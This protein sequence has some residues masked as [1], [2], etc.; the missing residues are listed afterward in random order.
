MS[1]V[2]WKP[3][4]AGVAIV[5]ALLILPLALAALL[6]KVGSAPVVTDV[7]GQAPATIVIEPTSERLI[8]QVDLTLSVRA[9]E[10]PAASGEGIVTAIYVA[11]GDTLR[12][13]VPLFALDGVDR[14]GYVP[15]QSHVFFRHLC[16]GS[17]GS[18]VELLQE[19]LGD[20][21]FTDSA[22]DGR[23]GRDTERA[24]KRLNAELGYS[25]PQACFDSAT[26]IALPSEGVEVATVGLALGQPLSATVPWITLRATVEDASVNITGGATVPDGAYELKVNGHVFP[27]VVTAGSVSVD[28]PSELGVLV[29]SPGTSTFRGSMQSVD[30]VPMILLPA[31]SVL[32][33][34]DGKTCVVV[35]ESDGT[36]VSTNVVRLPTGVRDLVAIAPDASL[37][38]VS[39]VVAPSSTKEPGECR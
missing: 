25:A 3:R 6:T 28:D 26:M 27:A 22:P 1:H 11:P 5:S 2:E 21:G 4:V 35:E 33:G 20:L 38:G 36:R 7:T 16:T 30:D 8:A 29:T 12:A 10:S 31:T 39:V 15:R 24:V 34:S 19:I 23:F 14:L 18:D 17:S 32:F 37:E 9:L 13:G